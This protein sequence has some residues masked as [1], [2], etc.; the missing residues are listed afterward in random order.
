M[1]YT[2][3]MRTLYIKNPAAHNLAEKVSKR[4]GVTLTEA[5]IFSLQGQLSSQARPIDLKKI[6]AIQKKIAAMPILDSRTND[7]IL[8]Y[9]EFGIS[10]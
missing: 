10:R 3:I 7:E 5:V 4:M 1:V 8:G 9:D 6:E 2:R